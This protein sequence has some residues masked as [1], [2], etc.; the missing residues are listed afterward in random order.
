MGRKRLAPEKI[1]HLFV[2]APASFPRADGLSLEDDIDQHGCPCPGRVP[3]FFGDQRSQRVFE[4]RIEPVLRFD[5]AVDNFPLDAPKI[6]RQ[7]FL[8]HRDALPLLVP[9]NDLQILFRQLHFGPVVSS[10][11]V[12]LPWLLGFG[13]GETDEF[14]RDV[15][16]RIQARTGIA[17]AMIARRRPTPHVHPLKG[18]IE[19]LDAGKH[20]RMG[21]GRLP[22]GIVHHGEREQLS[23]L[24][25]V[26]RSGGRKGCEEGLVGR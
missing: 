21:L 15:G 20:F 4:L 2:E 5:L 10:P 8:L 16:W 19:V 26:C 23:W 9:D 14:G 18:M 1:S 25:R 24:S 11:F 13:E 17:D 22:E 12:G 3:P 6:R 7:I